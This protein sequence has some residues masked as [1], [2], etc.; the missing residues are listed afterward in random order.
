MTTT[1][2]EY[3]KMLET[4]QHNRNTE[5]QAQ[6]EL[7]EAIRHN[8]EAEKAAQKQAQASMKN[9][10]TNRKSLK[11]TARTSKASLITARANSRNAASNAKNAETNARNAAINQQNADTRA[12]EAYLKS[13]ETA[14]NIRTNA[15]RRDLIYAQ[16]DQTKASTTSLLQDIDNKDIAMLTKAGKAGQTLAAVAVLGKLTANKQASPALQA[17][18]NKLLGS[19]MKASDDSVSESER[20]EAEKEAEKQAKQYNKWASDNSYSAILSFKN[21]DTGK[22]EFI[23]VFGKN[24]KDLQKQKTKAQT[25]IASKYPGKVANWKNYYKGQEQ[26]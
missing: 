19:L 9:A 8:I 24:K 7:N 6:A 23:M 25:M 12:Y 1:Q 17:V 5:T 10:N 3:Q 4:V 20:K 13:Q 26:K 2:I 15:A 11:Y 16:A 14:D 21:K 18:A 22:M